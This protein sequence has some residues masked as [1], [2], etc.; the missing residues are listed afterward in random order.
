MAIAETATNTLNVSLNVVQTCSVATQTL[1]FPT[2]SF[3]GTISTP[4]ATITVTCNGG[5]TPPTI[6]IGVGANAIGAVVPRRMRYAGPPEAFVAYTLTSVATAIVTD[7]A[8][9]LI[10]NLD[11]TY[12]STIFASATVPASAPKGAYSDAVIMTVTYAP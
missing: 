9:T 8:L 6:T 4:P 11:A 7:T 12:S 5:A 2:N 3:G 1:T 10:D